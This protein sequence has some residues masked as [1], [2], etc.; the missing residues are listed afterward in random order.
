MELTLLHLGTQS[1]RA[2]TPP[3]PE[4]EDAFDRFNR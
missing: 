3:E 1:A 2:W 4:Q